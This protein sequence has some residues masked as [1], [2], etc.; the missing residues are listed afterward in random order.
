MPQGEGTRLR[1]VNCPQAPF[2]GSNDQNV[3]AGLLTAG[4]ERLAAIALAAVTLAP[5]AWAQAP[6][7]QRARPAATPAAAPADFALRDPGVRREGDGV[8]RR[9]RTR[10]TVVAELQQGTRVEGNARRGTWYRVSLSDGRTGWI[11]RVEG[12][13]SPNFAVDTTP[14]VMLAR[15]TAPAAPAGGETPAEGAAPSGPVP[16]DRVVQ[17]RPMGRPLEPVIPII[18]PAQVPPPSPLLPNETVPIPDRWRLTDQ[19]NLVNMRWFD[20]YNPNTIKGDRPVFGSEDIFFNFSAISD[21]LFE[22]RRLPTP[23]GAQSTQRPQSDDQF[24]QGK[25]YHVRA[26]T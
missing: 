8:R 21:T 15:P 6:E 25:Q 1:Y 9:R 5:C 19:L 24:G 17:Q 23:I 26:R 7:V 11:N 13:V 12:K 2:N 10:S 22:A 14:G 4:V 18:D 3:C 20:P 16:D